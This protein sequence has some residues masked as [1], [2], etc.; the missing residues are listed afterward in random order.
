MLALGELQAAMGPDSRISARAETLAQHPRLGAEV[1]PNTPRAW[2]VGVSPS[3][4]DERI[5]PN[6]HSV[7]WLVSGLKRNE[8][9]QAQISGKMP[10]KNPVVMYGDNSINTALSTGGQPIEAGAVTVQSPDQRSTGG[11]AYFI[12]DNGTHYRSWIYP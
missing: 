1:S 8:S 2:W 9:P 6:K 12:D 11:L 7:V 3:D 5:G 4:P 10:F